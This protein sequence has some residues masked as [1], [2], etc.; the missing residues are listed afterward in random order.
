MEEPTLKST[1]MD[2]ILMLKAMSIVK[3][4]AQSALCNEYIKYQVLSN[5]LPTDQSQAIYFSKGF[6]TILFAFVTPDNAA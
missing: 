2:L 4:N 3:S 6:A 5:K 1:A